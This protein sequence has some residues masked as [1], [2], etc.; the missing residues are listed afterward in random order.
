MLGLL[1]ISLLQ[2]SYQILPLV[3]MC[4]VF[5]GYVIINRHRVLFKHILL[6]MIEIKESVCSF[7]EQH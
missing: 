1:F 2:I 5:L 6:N 7:V 3:E 4:T